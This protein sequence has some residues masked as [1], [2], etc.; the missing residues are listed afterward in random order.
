VPW[1]SAVYVV[2]TPYI[3][4][5]SVCVLFYGKIFGP[6]PSSPWIFNQQHG[7]LHIDTYYSGLTLYEVLVLVQVG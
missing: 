7:V 4:N 3:A 5:V 2:H 6:G 1:A